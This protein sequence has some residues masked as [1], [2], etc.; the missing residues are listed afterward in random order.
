[1]VLGG[2][3]TGVKI[4]EPVKG[5]PAESGGLKA[6]D[7]ILRIDEMKIDGVVDLTQA[8]GAHRAGDSIEVLVLRGEKEEKLTIRLGARPLDEE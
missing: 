1:M 7:V 8:V 6:D 2:S 5:S 3:R 4:Q